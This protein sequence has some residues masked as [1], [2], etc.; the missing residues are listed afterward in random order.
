VVS[1]RSANVA[2][3]TIS[4]MDL[5]PCRFAGAHALDRL[6]LDDVRFAQPPAG[7]RRHHRVP[8]RWTRRQTIAE[9]QH[10]RREAGGE[11]WY[12]ADTQ[13]PGRLQFEVNPPNPEILTGIY[14]ALRKGRE[15]G[16]DEPG[17]ADF[18]YGEMEM[19]R[20]GGRGASAHRTVARAERW[21]LTAYWLVSGYGLRASRALAVLA[22]TIALLAIPLALWGFEPDRSYGQS[23]LFGA[24]SSVSFFRAPDAPLTDTGSIVEMLL[25]LAGPLLFGLAVLSLRGRVRR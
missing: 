21:I 5:R 6:R 9:E 4:A 8:I 19:R 13:A 18:Y 25:R 2:A 22:A 15:D 7:W 20:Q 1:M 11:G 17:A 3:L 12:E 24:Q 23:V 10:W 16:K 14:R